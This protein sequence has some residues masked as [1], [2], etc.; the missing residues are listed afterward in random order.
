ML[1]KAPPTLGPSAVENSPP[2][3]Q[4]LQGQAGNK[5]LG[6]PVPAVQGDAHYPVVLYCLLPSW[7]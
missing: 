3:P 7:S 4:Y 2:S 6:V 1:L 5:A